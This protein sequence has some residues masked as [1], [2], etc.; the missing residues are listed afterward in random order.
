M[1][2]HH[3]RKLKRRFS[4]L[5]VLLSLLLLSHLSPFSLLDEYA[6]HFIEPHIQS[7][8]SHLS[9][10]PCSITTLLP[11]LPSTP[12][13]LYYNTHTGT[14]TNLL[15]TLTRLSLPLD[16]FNPHQSTLYGTSSSRAKYLIRE[17]HVSWICAQYDI[18]ILGDTTPHARAILESLLLPPT[19]QCRSQIIVELTNRFDWGM[20]AFEKSA[21]YAIMRRVVKTGKVIWVVNNRV[22]AVYLEHKLRVNL[23][24]FGGVRLLRPLG[25]VEEYAYPSHLPPPSKQTYIARNHH[26]THIYSTLLKKL[27][28]TLIPPGQQFGGPT[29]LLKFKAFIDIPY[30]YSVMKFYENIAAGVVQVVPTPRFLAELIE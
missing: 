18:L 13:I 9:S 20:P 8:C 1:A 19:Q 24:E 12:K 21:Y 16:T 26:L 2:L 5:L 11:H 15:H 29:S 10:P 27:P 28:I 14:T 7:A 30:Q 22:E 6:I 23:N 17:G 25:V 4:C 3:P